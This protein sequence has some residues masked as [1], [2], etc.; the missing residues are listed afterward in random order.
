MPSY[1]TGTL[2]QWVI[3][4]DKDVQRELRQVVQNTAQ[5]LKNYLTDV[6]ASWEHKVQFRRVMVVSAA[7][8]KAGVKA[9][10]RNKDIFGYVDKGTGKYG[11]RGSAYK[12]K[13][14]NGGVLRFKGGYDARSRP[15]AG[16]G[17]APRANVGTGKAI[18]GWVSTKEVTHPGIRPRKFAQLFEEKLQPNFRRRVS[19]AIRRAARRN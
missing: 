14:K 10:G 18:G 17:S 13:P 16:P 9:V 7:L 6:T 15:P 5:E 2:R 4:V 19:N 12:I 11:A 8:I 1:R 3:S